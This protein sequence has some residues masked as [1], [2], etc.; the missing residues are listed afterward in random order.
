MATQSSGREYR[1]VFPICQI[2]SF[3]TLI[4]S[5]AQTL[6]TRDDETIEPYFI[7][8]SIKVK[9]NLLFSMLVSIKLAYSRNSQEKMGGGL[10]PYRSLFVY[11]KCTISQKQSLVT[12]FGFYC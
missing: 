2:I 4:Q 10:S 12:F 7:R 8:L 11:D 5:T 3:H 9:P 6:L 1:V